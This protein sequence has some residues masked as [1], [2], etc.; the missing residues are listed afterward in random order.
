MHSNSGKNQFYRNIEAIQV[1][2]QTI[3]K[4]SLWKL[5]GDLLIL[6]DDDQYVE[7]K[8]ESTLFAENI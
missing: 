5:K 8:F 6:V 7:V 3:D 2:G 4:G 1:E